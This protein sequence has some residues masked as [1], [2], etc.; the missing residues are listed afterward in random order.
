MIWLGWQVFGRIWD[1]RVVAIWLICVWVCCS[2]TVYSNEIKV[3]LTAT[4]NAS[5]V[6]CRKLVAVNLLLECVVTDCNLG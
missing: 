4:P 2:N 5:T 3:D 1:E 6:F